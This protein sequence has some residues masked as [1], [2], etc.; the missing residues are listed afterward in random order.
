MISYELAKELR[1]AGFPNHERLGIGHGDTFLSGDDGMA[2]VPT[3]SEL[4]EVCDVLLKGE[5][6]LMHWGNWV[7]GDHDGYQG[8][9]ITARAEGTTPEEAVARL[10]LTLNSEKAGSLPKE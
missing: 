4:V 6:D 8:D 7:A 9:W 5:L 3:L 10:W 2:Y 1:D